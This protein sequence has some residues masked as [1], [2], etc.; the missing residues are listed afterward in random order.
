MPSTAG[1]RPAASPASVARGFDPRKTRDPAAKRPFVQQLFTSIAPRYDWFNRLA[2][3]GLDQRWR[4]AAVAQARVLP[5]HRVLD[6]CSGTGDLAML[7][8]TRQGGAGHVVG[9]DMNRAMLQRACAKQRAHGLPIGWLQGDAEALPFASDTF[10]RLFIGFS[11][12][13][14]SHLPEALREMVRVLRPGGRLAIVETGYPANPLLRA[15]YQ[16]FLFTVARTIGWVLTGRCWPFTYLARSV[17]QFLTPQQMTDG[18][19]RAGTQVEYVPLSG[20]LAS[21][22]LA[23]KCD[24]S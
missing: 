2:S 13:N 16:A 10:D 23:T 11:T 1:V 5:A 9:L 6:V 4:A 22:Y 14:L 7:C 18:L 19:Q 15:M 20:G 12:R 21:L 17:R 8:A 24:Q 3:F